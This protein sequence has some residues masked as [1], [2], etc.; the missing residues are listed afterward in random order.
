MQET[1]PAN[2]TAGMPEPR[3]LVT[4]RERGLRANLRCRE[5]WRSEAASGAKF[6]VIF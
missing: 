1:F 5:Q 2:K 6:G 3:S 4:I